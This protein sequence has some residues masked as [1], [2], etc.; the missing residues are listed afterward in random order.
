MG[1]RIT[2]YC[3]FKVKWTFCPFHCHFICSLVIVS[4]FSVLWFNNKLAMC[5]TI[6]ELCSG[7]N[8]PLILIS[9][10][11]SITNAFDCTIEQLYILGTWLTSLMCRC[12][13]KKWTASLCKAWRWHG[14]APFTGTLNFTNFHYCLLFFLNINFSCCIIYKLHCRLILVR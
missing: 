7:C 3:I 13:G 11:N 1:L 14:L 2:A 5:R 10:Y 12:W 6:K 4:C 8:V 9:Y